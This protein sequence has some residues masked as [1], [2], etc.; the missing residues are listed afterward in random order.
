MSAREQDAVAF[1][2]ISFGDLKRVWR[3]VLAVIVCQ[4]LGGVIG[5]LIHFHHSGFSNYWIGG[6]LATPLGFVVGLCWQVGRAE[7]RAATPIGLT[8]FLGFLAAFVGGF[9]LVVVF[10]RMREE[11]RRLAELRALHAGDIGQISVFD[12]YGKRQLVLI[13]DPA[14]ISD[15]AEA[16]R[17]VEGDS[18]SHP[19][20]TASWYVVIDG[21]ERH[22]FEFH[23]EAERPRE[24]VGYF[25]RKEGNTTRFSGSFASKLLRAWFNEH[26]RSAEGHRSPRV[27][28]PP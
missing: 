26:V 10:P 24:V 7:R 17:D 4:E 14:V 9:A 16:C 25:V 6:A 12:R 1:G 15:F 5:L 11:M 27:Q 22:E 28:P 18:P 20:Y 3:I 23:F 21:R 8:L 13:A 19:R 2:Q